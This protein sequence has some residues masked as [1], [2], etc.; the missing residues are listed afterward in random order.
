LLDTDF[1]AISRRYAFA[2]YFCR[3]TIDADD[4][5]DSVFRQL[6]PAIIYIL[7]FAAADCH[8]SRQQS[9]FTP[10]RVF[11]AAVA[12][13]DAASPKLHYQRRRALSFAPISQA[14]LIFGFQPSRRRLFFFIDAAVIAERCRAITAAAFQ[15]G[16]RRLPG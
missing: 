5:A 14:S 1:I 10:T 15:F 13:A 12:A 11:I 9:A 7:R 3:A 4:F 16:C 2:E 6:T 8:A